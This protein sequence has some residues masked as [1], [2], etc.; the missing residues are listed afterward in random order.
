ME[1]RKYLRYFAI[2]TAAVTL[3]RLW[4]AYTLGLGVDEAH[5]VQYAL[6]PALSYYDHPPMVGYLIRFFIL[7]CG[8][9]PL[10][11][12]MPAVLSGAGTAILLFM[13][14]KKL[15][16]AAAGFWT[17]VIFNCIPIFSAIG[18][19]T[20]VPDTLLCFFYL[21]CMLLLWR[22]SETGNGHLWYAAGIVTGVSLLTKYTAALLY[23]SI[24][25]FI[26]LVPSMRKWFGKKELYLSFLLS[27]LIFLPVVIWNYE[28][29]W[30]SFAFQ[31][32]HGL[33][34]KKF[35]IAEEF[36]KNIGAQAGVFSPF[37]FVFIIR[38]LFRTIAM[39]L[40]KN[41]QYL[42]FLSFA[43]PVILVFGYSGLSNQVLPHWP[44]VGYLV[45]LPVLGKDACGLLGGTAEKKSVRRFFVFSLAAGIALT[46]IIPV[47]ALFKVIPVS[48]E[49]D[50]TNDMAGWEELADRI[51][52]IR[53]QEADSDFF[54]FT[55][56]F[57]L[58]GQL[59]FY[60]EPEIP[61][62]CLSKRVDQYDF[63][64]YPQALQ[65]KLGGRNGIFFRDSNYKTVPEKLYAFREIQQEQPFEI[66]V[67]GRYAKSFYLY[68]CYDFDTQKT[69]P[70]VLQ[71]LPFA[72][73]SFKAA[74]LVSHL[75]PLPRGKREDVR[76]SL[77]LLRSWNEKSFLLI[78]GLARRNRI[79]DAFFM[80][81]NWLGTSYV[82]IPLTGLLIWMRQRKQ[83]LKYFWM[84]A[85]AMLLGGIAVHFMKEFFSVPRPLAYFEEDIVNIVGDQL[86]KG[87]FPSGH[88][89]TVFTGVLFLSW[90][91]PQYRSAFWITGVLSG[92]SRCYMGAH[93]PFDVIAGFFVALLSFLVVKLCCGETKPT[94]PHHEDSSTENSG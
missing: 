36:L 49:N 58:A 89:Q 1:D 53:T 37:I 9:Y 24:F 42:L 35:F 56:T 45:L 40:R 15:H 14:G 70:A 50:I 44:A 80:L 41:E 92:I 43:L 31:F 61:V 46:L 88:A 94:P 27:L 82:L 84:F 13:L 22:I 57:Y 74:I 60:L 12:R 38:S 7:A 55:H 18:G 72:P 32:S 29:Y 64:Q 79:A 85:L 67:K 11:A 2:L 16:G 77:P 26:L 90:L 81:V 6:N 51:R 8:K 25:I 68:R 48:P 71:S 66:H 28:N 33:G 10:A 63:W 65:Q 47:Q 78:N 86:K 62:Y 4:L 59:A 17:A 87:S 52:E 69:D 3:T 54:V 19:I 21:L 75:N 91:I 83:F 76:G 34:E 5:Y 39:S 93:F 30:F 20:I 23:P 73:R